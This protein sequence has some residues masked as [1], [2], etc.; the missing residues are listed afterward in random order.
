MLSCPTIEISFVLIQGLNYY[1]LDK[2]MSWCKD[3]R[4]DVQTRAS[5]NK[6]A[7]ADVPLINATVPVTL[8]KLI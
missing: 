6:V 8:M 4:G 5:G 3:A 2:C 7:S 1:R